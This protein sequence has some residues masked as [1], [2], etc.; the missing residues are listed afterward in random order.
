VIFT[1]KLPDADLA[2]IYAL[3]DV[4]AMPSREQLDKCSVEGFGL[5]FLEANACGKAVVGGR[6]GGIPDAIEDGVTGFLVNPNDPDDTAAA[7]GRILTDHEL[8][9]RMGT[10]GR[11]RVVRTFTWQATGKRVQ[12]I[13]DSVVLK[14]EGRT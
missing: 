4:F 9:S 3:S 7:I 13:L 5:V 8:A 10:Q 2:E 12:D 6:S 14:T 1:G 11:A